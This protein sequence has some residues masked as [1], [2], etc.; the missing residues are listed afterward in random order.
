MKKLF[1]YVSIH[2][3]AIAVIFVHITAARSE[4]SRD[5]LVAVEEVQYRDYAPLLT[6]TGT[7]KARVQADLS[8]RIGG[9]ITERLADVGDHVRAGD[10][11]ARLDDAEQRTNLTA[12]KAAEN[13]ARAELTQANAHYKRQQQLL[14]QGFSTRSQFE[15]AEQAWITAQSKLTSAE[16]QRAN[17]ENE[18][19]DTELRAPVDG[20]ITSRHVEVG[21]IVQAAQAGFLLA[22]DGPRDA[23]FDVQE[24]LVKHIAAHAD[25]AVFLLSDQSI[26]AQGKVREISPVVDAQTGTVKVKVALTEED[27]LMPLG[28]VLSGAL[29]LSKQKAAI[30]SWSSLTSDRGKPA[31]WRVNMTDNLV[32]L[33]PVEVLSFDRERVI[34]TGGV[35]EGELVVSKGGQMLRSGQR[36]EIAPSQKSETDK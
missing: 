9:Q 17:A 10:L 5:L 22:K 27:S 35:D 30:L 11:L 19:E 8:F 33:V 21:Q 16:S 1:R 24:M 26:A 2:L 20:V 15:Q 4:M 14:S 3:A 31:V 25:I 13:A 12:A 29:Q 6:F 18:L 23:V 7:L 28:A 34:I 36:V 32:S